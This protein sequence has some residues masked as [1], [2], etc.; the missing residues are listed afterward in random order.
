MNILHQKI[1]VKECDEHV[2]TLE[3]YS[4]RKA[5]ILKFQFHKVLLPLNKICFIMFSYRVLRR[6]MINIV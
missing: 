1:P 3:R 4:E 5:Y 2:A 6:L